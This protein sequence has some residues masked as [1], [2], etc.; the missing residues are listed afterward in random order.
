G[1]KTGEEQSG[2]YLVLRLTGQP[3]NLNA[4]GATAI[5]FAGDQRMVYENYPTRGYQAAALGPLHVGLGDASKVDSVLLVWPDRTYQRLPTGNYNLT[6]ELL[7]QPGLPRFDFSSIPVSPT[8]TVALRDITTAVGLTHLHEENPFVDFSRE[9]LIPH[10]VSAEGPA[11]AVGDI[12]G[13]GRED[14]F[15]GSSKRRRSALYRQ[16]AN[17]TFTLL[18]APAIA[19]DSVFED[20]DACFVDLENDGDLDLIVAAG[21]NEYERKQAPRKQ[22]AYLNDG[23]GNFTRQDVFPDIFQTASRVL[24]GDFNGDGLMDFFLAGR[25]VPWNYGKVPPSYLLQNQGGN[26]FVDVTADVAP[27]LTQ[28]G[29][30]TDGQWEDVDGDGDQDLVLAPEW[31]PITIYQNDGKTLSSAPVS[32]QTGWWKHVQ[33]AD[34]DG[35]GDVDILAGNTGENNKLQPS[36][37]E[38]LRMYVN[39]FDDNEK[40]EQVLTYYVKGRE[41]PFAS[42]AELIKQLPPLKKKYLFAQDMAKEPLAT[43]FGEAKLD[44]ALQYSVNTLT[45]MYFEQADNGDFIPHRL[46][47]AAQFSSLHASTPSGVAEDGFRQFLIGG[48][49]LNANIEMGWYDAGFLQVLEVGPAG[50]MRVKALAGTKINGQIRNLRSINCAGKPAFLVARND[51]SLRLVE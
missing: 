49:F 10:M 28:A 12:D 24:P 26:S 44:D 6:L 47:D 42:H 33:V 31:G 30:I 35:D 41:I 2:D 39:D 8:E 38:P 45:N 22:R 40:M 14:F 25:V 15:I 48:N 21:G 9:T 3:T 29:L 7:W 13:D 17:G 20:V 5:A 32:E 50:K 34:F 46:P 19:Q 18:D 36:P 51:A 4:I 1:A 37:E 16:A 43:I 11:L 27:Q 23:V